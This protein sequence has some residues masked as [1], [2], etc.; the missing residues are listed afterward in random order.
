MMDF[1]IQPLLTNWRPFGRI[2]TPGLGLFVGACFSVMLDDRVELDD[3]LF[4][5]LEQGV[6][7]V[8]NCNYED[9][10]ESSAH[11]MR[12]ACTGSI[13]AARRAGMMPAIAAASTST[14]MATAITGTFT[15]VIS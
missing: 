6:S 10:Y 8:E 1:L 5:I 11:S 7:W 4:R 12:K 14:P 15:L 2:R 13:E 9:R 3:C